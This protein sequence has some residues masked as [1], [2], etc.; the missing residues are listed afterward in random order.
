MII[1]P[2]RTLPH[3]VSELIQFTVSMNRVQDYLNTPEVD[4]SLV[5]RNFNPNAEESIVIRGGNNFHWGR[6][7]KKEESDDEDDKKHE[8]VL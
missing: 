3:F 2:L 5:Q 4:N 1:G 8:K 6:D 7:I